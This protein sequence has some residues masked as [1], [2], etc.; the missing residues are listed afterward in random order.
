MQTA[1]LH[2]NIFQR[3][4]GMCATK[5]P[6]DE[7]CWTF[8]DGKIIV[9]LARAPELAE[10]NGAMRLEAK[11]LPARVLV[12][13]GDDGQY[14]AF[15]N[16]CTHGKRRLDPMPGTQQVQCC[17]VGRSIFDYEGKYI[18]GSAKSDIETYPVEVDDGKLVITV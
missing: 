9:D 8:N 4:L 7:G 13:Q 2:R 3:V 17:S 15:Q 6:S 14:R 12:I 18:S 1:T 16:R 10:P 5:K 11:A